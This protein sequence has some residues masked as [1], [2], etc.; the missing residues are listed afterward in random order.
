M[1]ATAE[2]V[3]AFSPV[4]EAAPEPRAEASWSPATRIAF[5]FCFLYF[6]LYVLMTQML[7]GLLPNPKFRVPVLAEKAPMRPL[8]IW[9]G[10]TCSA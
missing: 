1:T 2:Y 7:A 10:T 5:R 3:R 4:S 8:V 6:G 9:V